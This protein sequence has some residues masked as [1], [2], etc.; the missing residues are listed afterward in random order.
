MLNAANTSSGQSVGTPD[1]CNTPSGS[2]DVPVPYVN[3]ASHAQATNP[4]RNVFLKSLPALNQGS[5]VPTSSGDEAGTSHP[6]TRGAQV[7]TA[8]NPRVLLGSLPAITLTSPTTQNNGNCPSGAVTQAG[9]TNVFFSLSSGGLGPPAVGEELRLDA[10]GLRALL[11]R[12]WGVC[13][14]GRR[15]ARAWVELGALGPGTCAALAALLAGPLAGARHLALDLRGSPGG[16]LSEAVALTGLFLP[17]RTPVA[18]AALRARDVALAA[19]RAP[20]A[21]RGELALHVGPRT[22]SAAEVLAGA[23]SAA[24]RARVVGART[25]GKGTIQRLRGARLA[26]VGEVWLAGG[27]RLHG[28]GVA[29]W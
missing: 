8:G 28:E 11:S 26:T 9:A 17:A 23:L 5:V 15:A 20:S 13:A 27:A 29:P 16:L 12:R 1:V 3:T 7:F 19:P 6:T 21:F 10:A 24:G 4:A 22:A 25:Y 18:V 14:W 2:V